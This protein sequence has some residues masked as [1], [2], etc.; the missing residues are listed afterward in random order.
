MVRI[1]FSNGLMLVDGHNRFSLDFEAYC[2]GDE[3]GV[4]H[5]TLPDVHI[6]KGR[7]NYDQ[8]SINDVVYESAVEAVYAFNT[9]TA[10]ALAYL[11][12]GLKANTEYPN[13][14]FSAKITA[15][16]ETQIASYGY[17]GY[18]T[19]KADSGNSGNVYIGPA[20]LNSDS[21]GLE[22]GQSVSYEVSD[23]TELYAL[24]ASEG[25]IIYVFGAFRQ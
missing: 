25:D 17:Q 14:P 19:I 9:H 15:N 16:A 11:W 3:V 18:V 6:F 12:T 4:R 5:V 13:T 20:G 7:V 24:N 22:A 8:I 2:L 21:G 10:A 23:L 1:T